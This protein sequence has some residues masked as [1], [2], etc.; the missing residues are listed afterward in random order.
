MLLTPREIEPEPRNSVCNARQ[1]R[2]LRAAA[3]QDT[4]TAVSTANA[5]VQCF[6]TPFTGFVFMCL[7]KSM[8]LN[9]GV[10]TKNHIKTAGMSMGSC[11]GAVSV[12]CTGKG[13]KSEVGVTGQGSL[14]A[15]SEQ[16]F[17]LRIPALAR[18]NAAL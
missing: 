7:R 3:C 2:S 16:A 15:G 9:K 13:Y 14:R 12:S 18:A 1:W 4:A 10:N 8:K 6:V 11:M 5:S 17:R